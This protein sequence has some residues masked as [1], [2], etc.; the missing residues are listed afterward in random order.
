MAASVPRFRRTL[1]IEQLM[2]WLQA[3]CLEKGRPKLKAKDVK[4]LKGKY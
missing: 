3:K 4:K 1:T 2:S